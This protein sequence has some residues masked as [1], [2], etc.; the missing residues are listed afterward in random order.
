MYNFDAASE[1]PE[2]LKIGWSQQ[3]RIHKSYQHKIKL[4]SEQAYSLVII[5]N[6]RMPS[7]PWT[8]LSPLRFLNNA[9]TSN[10]EFVPLKIN[11]ICAIW[12]KIIKEKTKIFPFMGTNTVVFWAIHLLRLGFADSRQFTYRL[13]PVN[14]RALEFDVGSGMRKSSSVHWLPRLKRWHIRRVAYS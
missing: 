12:N 7:R 14:Q 10:V 11:R 4:I 2:E 5:I 9:M 3:E 1:R 13:R 6:K 8:T